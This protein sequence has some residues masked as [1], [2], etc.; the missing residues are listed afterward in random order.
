MTSNE[1]KALLL[2]IEELELRIEE[3]EQQL[4]IYNENESENEKSKEVT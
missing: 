3:L 1:N 2:R 4:K